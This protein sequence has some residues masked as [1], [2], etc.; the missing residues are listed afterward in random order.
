[1]LSK[2]FGQ[3]YDKQLNKIDEAYLEGNYA[4]S[5]KATDKLGAELEKINAA[6]THIYV[7]YKTKNAR[8]YLANKQLWLFINEIK[9][10]EELNYIVNKDN[11]Y[12]FIDNALEIC[13]LYI[14]YGNYHKSEEYLIEIEQQLFSLRESNPY[15]ESKIGLFKAKTLYG[16]GYYASSLQFIEENIDYYKNR[17]RT[18]EAYIDKKTGNLRSRDLPEVE[19]IK[20][21]TEYAYMKQLI[22]LNLWQQGDSQAAGIEFLETLAWID[23]QESLGKGSLVYLETSFMNWQMSK[24]YGLDDKKLRKECE[25]LLTKVRSN[26]FKY[27][28]LVMDIYYELLKLYLETNDE[29]YQFKLDFYR[30]LALNDYPGTSTYRVN[31]EILKI[32]KEKDNYTN[33]Q[34]QERIASVSKNIPNHQIKAELLDFGYTQ[35][36]FRKNYKGIGLFAEEIV[37]VDKELFGEFSP[38]YHLSLINYA[39]YLLDYGSNFQKVDSIYSISF[40]NIV[41]PQI[42]IGH[43]DYLNILNHLAKFY[44]S[45]DQ[46]EFASGVLDDAAKTVRTMYDNHDYEYGIELN[47]ISSLQIKIGSFKEAEGN[48]KKAS[49]ILEQ[50]K[51]DEIR[52]VYYAETLQNKAKLHS[53]YGE[54]D[55]AELMLNRSVKIIKKS[56][57]LHGYD[58]LNGRIDIAELQIKLGK[59]ED[60]K[61]LLEETISTYNEIYGSTSRHL[62]RPLISLGNFQLAT[63]N[64]SDAEKNARKAYDIASTSLGIKSSKAGLC[65]NLL[66][67]YFITIGDYQKAL[68]P[69]ISVQ[70]IYAEK[71]GTDH[72]NYASSLAKNAL[73][74]F[75]LKQDF[76]TIDSLY[77]EALSITNVNLGSNSPSYAEI[78]SK[79]ALLYIREGEYSIAFGKINQAYAIWKSRLGVRNN[80]S[81]ADIFELAGD[82]YYH[83]REYEKSTEFYKKA[84]GVYENMF[85]ESHPKYIDLQFKL[86]KV[87]YMTKDFRK[88]RKAMDFVIETYNSF[89]DVYFPSLSEREKTKF[90]NTIKPAYEFYN[91]VALGFLSQSPRIKARML[92]NALNTKSLLLNT[93]L[94]TRDRILSSNDVVLI[95]K[96]NLWQSKKG[97]LTTILS[98]SKDQISS[99]GIN[100]PNLTQEVDLLE[101]EI[102]ERSNQFNSSFES[103]SIDWKDIKASLKQNEVAIEMVR[104]RYFDQVFTDSIIYAVFYFKNR[105]SFTEPIVILLPNGKDLENKYYKS[106]RNSIVFKIPDRFS[107]AN[108]WKPIIGKIGNTSTIYLSADGVYNQINL[109]TI[110]V[111]EDK[112]VIDNSNIILVS[113]TKDVYYNTVQNRKNSSSTRAIIIGNPAYYVTSTRPNSGYLGQLTGT[114]KEVKELDKVLTKNGFETFTYLDKEATESMVKSIKNPKIF[115]IATHGFFKEKSNNRNEESLNLS[116]EIYENPLLRTGLMLSGAGDILNKTSFNY[117]IEDGILTAYEVMNLSFDETDLVVLSACET[118]LGDVTAG[119]GVYGL[120]RAFIVAGAKTLIMSMFKVD[121]VATQK[122]MVDFYQKW[123]DTGNKRQSFLDAKKELRN[124]PEFKEPIYWG[125]FIMIGLD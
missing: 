96:F 50:L 67:D 29:R 23:A 16:Q 93:S 6:N 100:V 120:Q 125:A 3:N 10:V 37:A 35:S 123:I 85:S 66:A 39:H 57:N 109:E 98:M 78:L 2:S 71:Y 79:Q 13:E 53:I 83:M 69:S 75:Y 77:N 97:Q 104:F 64:Y 101:K 58:D 60:S 73:I 18:R 48:I 55:E 94:K 27:H 80:L 110:P 124:N 72:I 44:E 116:P 59:Y 81:K 5:I 33:R 65:L 68:E 41:K 9:D 54:F 76:E 25:G 46:F 107:Y 14:A 91:T 112:Y 114:V 47:K 31:V 8:N 40:Q 34:M 74:R 52:S 56:Y 43:K 89:I 61:E 62:I 28:Y 119:E 42:K 99:S 45:T 117:N 38:N 19:I 115:H 11:P 106:Y 105:K 95:E 118:G 102:S 17:A 90:W 4:K 63:G 20:S 49:D 122:L 113:N 1:V 87:Y 12:N 22:C 88:A 70:N 21:Y 84:G 32:Y 15:F 36:I 121:D 7:I 51:N 24:Q 103:Q 108:Y 26:L 30:E 92:N 111:S 82:V 86:G